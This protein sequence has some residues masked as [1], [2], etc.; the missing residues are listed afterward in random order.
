MLA[1]SQ[2]GAVLHAG[3]VRYGLAIQIKLIRF[4]IELP[5]PLKHFCDLGG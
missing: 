2:S 4:T 1:T 5:L 3:F